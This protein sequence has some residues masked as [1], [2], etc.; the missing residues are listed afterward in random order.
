MLEWVVEKTLDF[1]YHDPLRVNPMDW[2]YTSRMLHELM[3][4]VHKDRRYGREA[5]AAHKGA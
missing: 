5:K 4:L 1:D 2:F 3:C